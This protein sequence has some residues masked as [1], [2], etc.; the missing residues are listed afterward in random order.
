[1]Q[2]GGEGSQVRWRR[3]VI[4]GLVM[5]CFY[6]LGWAGYHAYETGFSG[7]WRAAVQDAF[8]ARGLEIQFAR[9]TLDPLEGLVAREVE[10]YGDEEGALLL[11][12]V[13]SVRIDLDLERLVRGEQIFVKSVDLRQA[14]LSLPVAPGEA[15]SARVEIKDLDARIYLHGDRIDVRGAE[16]DFY[17]LRCRLS[18][19][20]LGVGSWGSSPLGKRLA[21]G[22][23]EGRDNPWPGR[24]R[25]LQENLELLEIDDDDPP[26]LEIAITGDLGREESLDVSLR[27]GS[28][29]M[30][31]RGYRCRGMELRG[32]LR[33]AVA[34]LDEFVLEDEAGELRVVGHH[35]LRRRE[36][37]FSV[38]SSAQLDGL[39]AALSGARLAGEL[40]CYVAPRL[41]LEGTWMMGGGELEERE[42]GELAWEVEGGGAADERVVP[43]VEKGAGEALMRVLPLRLVGGLALGRFAT[44]GVV[45]EGLE[46]R[47]SYD[48]GRYFLRDVAVEHRGGRMVVNAMQQDE[49]FRGRLVSGLPLE[50]LAPFL[51][52]EWGR[53][54]LARVETGAESSVRLDLE[55][56]GA[57]FVPGDLALRGRV[58][59][60]R[61][62]LAGEP[63]LSATAEIERMEGEDL[64]VR[65]LRVRHATGELV[66]EAQREGDVVSYELR[67]GLAP[68]VLASLLPWEG[69]RGLLG[70]LEVGEE[71][72]WLEIS[73]GGRADDLASWRHRGMIRLGPFA[74]GGVAGDSLLAEIELVPGRFELIDFTMVRGAG[75]ARGGYV[76]EREDGRHS[77][78]IE[79]SL[80][81][82]VMMPLLRGEGLL[83]LR[84]VAGEIDLG[85]DGRAW[86]S[87]AGGGVG[88][89]GG[90]EHRGSV[91]L[92]RVGYRGESFLEVAGELEVGG[93]GGWHLKEAQVEHESGRARLTALR[94]VAGFRYAVASS[95]DFRV[96]R[97]FAREEDTRK[98]LDDFEFGAGSGHS[99]EIRGMGPGLDLD[100]SQSELVVDLRN[101]RWRGMEVARF[102]S[103]ISYGDGRLVLD[104]LEL[105]RAEGKAVARR[106]ERLAREDITR[107]EGLKAQ[108]DPVEATRPF[109]KAVSGHL[110]RYRFEGIPSFELDGVIH[111][112]DAWATRLAIGIDAPELGYAIFGSELPFAGVGGTVRFEGGWVGLELGAEL[113][114]G[115]VK[116]KANLPMAERLAQARSDWRVEVSSVGVGMLARAYQPEA[117]SEGDLPGHVAFTMGRGGEA[118]TVNGEG[119]AIIAN[120]DLYAL[121][122]LGPLTVI[123]SS[124]LPRPV[125]GYSVAREC[126]ATFVIER[127]VVLMED[128][129]AL[130]SVFRIRG[131]GSIDIPQDKVELDMKAN[132]RGAAGFVF[133]PVSEILEYR[134]EGTVGD[135]RWRPKHFTRG[136]GGRGRR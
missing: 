43:E 6:G 40:V 63:V 80:S 11:A 103:D 25:R 32:G 114:G 87:F 42:N 71:S 54:I 62:R 36:V 13:D 112:R 118:A 73:G 21:E 30:G 37:D 14:R 49:D 128:F 82:A 66:G 110:E 115:G 105:E 58:E 106:V 10:I 113:F 90:W 5:S 84:E 22:A 34:R 94:D 121:P 33:G 24:W 50:V 127:G 111:G 98:F 56:E 55:A 91:R 89:V 48:R 101:F 74:Y 19:S 133:F 132:V 68:G 45:F 108:L 102:R 96:V 47:F 95:L 31:L 3:L 131:G 64:A 60:A 65:E 135:T 9:L 8:R 104:N 29:A 57:R 92:E 18:V 23:G 20:V 70:Q 117:T 17:G 81:P 85:T 16:W 125:A 97:A 107:I 134:G 86:V 79:S 38:S 2:Q 41:E 12:A 4:A 126:D 1:M 52:E 26:W 100:L 99:L 88:E 93:G 136:A 75:E 116:L 28:G 61:V 119:V 69:A 130:T 83:E 53:A 77:Y 15:G 122:I 109:S 39:V 120:G 27:G 59:V 35:V 76:Y 46:G 129:E 123:L 51:T 78:R 67:S 124:V 7:P 72:G 44:R